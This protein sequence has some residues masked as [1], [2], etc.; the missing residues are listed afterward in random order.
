[1]KSFDLQHTNDRLSPWLHSDLYA[2]LEKLQERLP[3]KSITSL[4][5]RYAIVQLPEHENGWYYHEWFGFWQV[6]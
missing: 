2:C 1:M 5:C 6:D 3:Q 4:A